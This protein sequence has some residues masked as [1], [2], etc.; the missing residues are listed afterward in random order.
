[1]R[2]AQSQHERQY[3]AHLPF[4]Q[5]RHQFDEIAGAVPVIQ[6]M[7]QNLVPSILHRAI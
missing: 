3:S 7:N 5:T 1:M 2:S 4:G 6:L